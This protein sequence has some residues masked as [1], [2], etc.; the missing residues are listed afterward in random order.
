MKKPIYDYRDFRLSRLN[1]PRF[2]HAKLLV[3]WIIYFTMYFVT[4]NLIPAEKCFP[5]HCFMDDI[6]PFCEYFVVPYYL[7]YALCFFSLL[8]FF[9]YDVDS[10]K[11]LQTYIMITQ[12]IAML[13]YIFF[14]TRQDLRPDVFPRHNIFTWVIENLYKFDTSTGVCPSLHVAYSL[15][16]GSVWFKYKLPYKSVK[17]NLWKIFL[18][19]FILSI[20]LATSFIKQHSFVDIITAI[21]V[22]IVAEIFT[23]HVIRFKPAMDNYLER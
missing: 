4:E 17:L 3:G 21:P 23:F 5:V 8:Y 16:I 6:I 18:V 14:P 11:R 7:W 15:G 20:C 1:D 22:G 12:L 9:L 2:A 10:F 19:P 13:C